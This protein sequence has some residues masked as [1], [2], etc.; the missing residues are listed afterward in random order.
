MTLPP[1]KAG[2]LR[3]P[4]VFHKS[5]TRHRPSEVGGDFRH[6]GLVAK[7]TTSIFSRKTSPEVDIGPGAG[8]TFRTCFDV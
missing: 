5:G 7:M 6:S 1:C 3:Y 8:D 4:D 2:E